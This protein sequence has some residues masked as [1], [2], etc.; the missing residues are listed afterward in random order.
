MRGAAAAPLADMIGDC[1][2]VAARLCAVQ[3]ARQRC[4]DKCVLKLP[5]LLNSP[6]QAFKQNTQTAIASGS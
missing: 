5:D 2:P 1:V 6:N 4:R 3:R